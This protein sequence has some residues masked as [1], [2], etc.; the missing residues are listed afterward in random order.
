MTKKL[1]SRELKKL[2]E[3][4]TEQTTVTSKIGAIEIQKQELIESAKEINQEISEFMAKL[5]DKYGDVKIDLTNGKFITNDSEFE[6]SIEESV[7]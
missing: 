4:A 3:L 2:Q 5:K 6:E 1:T 7:N